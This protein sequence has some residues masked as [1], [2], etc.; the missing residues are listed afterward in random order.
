M[1]SSS[2]KSLFR[3]NSSDTIP[4]FAEN[5]FPG[6]PVLQHDGWLEAFETRTMEQYQLTSLCLTWRP[7]SRILTKRNSGTMVPPSAVFESVGLDIPAVIFFLH[8]ICEQPNNN[9]REIFFK[10]FGMSQKVHQDSS[11]VFDFFI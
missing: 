5:L 11:V 8:S 4:N 10:H 3:C 9:L 6:S 7:L 2:E 1:E